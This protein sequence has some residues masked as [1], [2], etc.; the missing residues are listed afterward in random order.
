MV[1]N[2]KRKEQPVEHE[3]DERQLEH[4]EADVVAELR[5]V[6]AERL[7]VAEHEPVLPTADGR[8]CEQQA[9]H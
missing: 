5:I 7:A 4:V 8:R 9:E 6:D 1:M 3:R 2:S